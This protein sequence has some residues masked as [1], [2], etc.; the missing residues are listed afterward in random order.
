MH[1]AADSE[2]V[3]RNYAFPPQEEINLGLF[4][5]SV[6]LS[7]MATQFGGNS[8]RRGPD[9][10][11]EELVLALSGSASF[12]FKPL[13]DI[14][15][16]NLRARKKTSGGE[17]MM[18]LRAYEKLQSLVSQGMVKKTITKAG[19]HYK[20]LVSLASFVPVGGIIPVV[21]T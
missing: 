20:G 3:N 16:E 15:Y 18:R 1:H 21:T 5:K 2:I 4:P 11:T 8:S 10:I 7:P 14:I 13:F 17:E 19:K 9:L 12:E 6:L